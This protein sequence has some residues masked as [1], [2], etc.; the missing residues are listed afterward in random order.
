MTRATTTLTELARYGF[1][2]LGVAP[3]R[4]WRRC[5]R[6]S[7][8]CSPR[9]PIPTRRCGSCGAARD[10]SGCR[11]R[12]PGERRTRP[13]GCCAC[14]A[15][16]RAWRA[17]SPGI[18]SSSRRCAI[19]SPRRSNRREV[20]ARCSPQPS[21]GLAG[22]AGWNALRIA[23]RR[24][25][26]RL[27]AWDL[28]QPDGARRRRPGRAPRS[29]TSPARRSTPRCCWRAHREPSPRRRGRRDPARDHRH[30]QVGRARAQLPE[31]RRRDLRRRRATSRS[32]PGSRWTP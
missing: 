24:E 8:R 20:R 18:P 4:R 3:A 6:A 26:L 21:T 30:G 17:S 25:L 29:P 15:R 2:D 10:G 14:S 16:P 27:A 7:R 12:P 32:P 13:S 1:A 22:E 31:R 19:R 28:E 5:R 9:P 11:G 23:Y